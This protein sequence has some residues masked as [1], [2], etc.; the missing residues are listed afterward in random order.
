MSL[1][2]FDNEPTA[3]MAEQR[4]KLEGIPCLIR[5]LRG[6][7]GLWGSAYNLPHD[8]LVYE[9]DEMRAREVLEYVPQEILERERE[10]E[11]ERPSTLMPQW[12]ITLTIVA[13]AAFIAL[14]VVIANR[15]VR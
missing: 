1:R 13:V 3:R 4:L 14:T 5:S 12:M 15:A 6:G 2:V 10:Q 11:G 9:G 8:L 7:P